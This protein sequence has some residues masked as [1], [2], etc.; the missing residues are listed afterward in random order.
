MKLY[1]KTHKNAYQTKESQQLSTCNN[2]QLII[3]NLIV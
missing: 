2:L 3:F 1:I